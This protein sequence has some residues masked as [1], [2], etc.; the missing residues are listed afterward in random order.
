MFF[1]GSRYEKLPTVVVTLPGGAVV[2]AVTPSSPS[3]APL[4]GFHRL[5][6]AQR[7]DLVANRYL[8]DATTFWRL[9][10]ASGAVSPDAL[11]ART[12][13]AIPTKDG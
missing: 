11:A 8:S 4:L 7:L 9:C 12:L 5:T 6:A 3:T 10:D 1:P 2:T 13:V